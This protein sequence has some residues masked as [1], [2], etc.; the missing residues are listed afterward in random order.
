M[1]FLINSFKGSLQL[2]LEKS[3][4]KNQYFVYMYLSL[5]IQWQHFS[6]FLSFSSPFLKHKK[7]H[8]GFTLW[9]MQCI[10]TE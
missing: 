7:F 5:T 8:E 3:Y 9:L 10:C 2:T 1:L 4:A 6:G